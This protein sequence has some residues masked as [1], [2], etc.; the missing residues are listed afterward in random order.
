M[1]KTDKIC[2]FDLGKM[3]WWHSMY[4]AMP[5]FASYYVCWF[6]VR[7]IRG[8]IRSYLTTE[9][10]TATQATRRHI[11][12]GKIQMSFIKYLPPIGVVTIMIFITHNK[13]HEKICKFPS[14]KAAL[15]FIVIESVTPIILETPMLIAGFT[16]TA[17]LYEFSALA[18]HLF[19]GVFLAHSFIDPIVLI[20]MT[21]P[22]KRQ[23]MR[24][25]RRI[26]PVSTVATDWV[27][28]SF[29]MFSLVID[30]F[31]F[32][33]AKNWIWRYLLKQ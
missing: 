30:Y 13:Y 7:K 18:M 12:D 22:Y 16:T 5:M 9:A 26:M 19:V 23:L 32:I 4:T 28:K 29:L 11:S 25:Y 21:R 15:K 1:G 2:S 10:T 27:W 6:C 3:N 14:A 33:A 20:L 31:W 17:K 24:M 8:H